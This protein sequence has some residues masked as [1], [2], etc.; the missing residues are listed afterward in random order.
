MPGL[1][2]RR[3]HGSLNLDPA[4]QCDPLRRALENPALRMDGMLSLS[5]RGERSYII[6]V[7]PNP[8][9]RTTR[10][11]WRIYLTSTVICA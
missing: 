11:D 3:Q 2:I 10:P 9:L 1:V 8:A 5:V 6:T 4:V 7:Y